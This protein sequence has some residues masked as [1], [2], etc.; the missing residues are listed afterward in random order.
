[1]TEI[2]TARD[3][4]RRK[5]EQA[6]FDAI[7]HRASIV[8]KRMALASDLAHEL[9]EGIQGSPTGIETFEAIESCSFKAYRLAALKIGAIEFA[10]A[11]ALNTMRDFVLDL[12]LAL[13]VFS[14]KAAAIYRALANSNYGKDSWL[15]IVAE[16][17]FAGVS[18]AQDAAWLAREAA[19]L[20]LD[21][22][23]LTAQR[24]K[25]MRDRRKAGF[26]MV[27]VAIHKHDIETFRRLGLLTG[28]DE[29]EAADLE[30]AA[31]SLMAGALATIGA[32][33]SEAEP[34]APTK[35]ARAM[36]PALALW[37]AGVWLDRLARFVAVSLGRK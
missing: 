34:E 25:R 21:D 33:D 6:R 1:M 31:Q 2:R 5:A 24:A 32:I 7:R 9:P 29:P 14:T 27:T 37:P 18:L 3:S 35:I 20:E 11:A 8:G 26:R 30:E 22:A 4:F 28:K 15:S 13:N 10:G 23:G 17:R 12:T 16:M 19:E 36:N